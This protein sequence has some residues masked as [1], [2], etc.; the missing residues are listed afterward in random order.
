MATWIDKWM[1]MLIFIGAVSAALALVCTI[2]SIVLR[3]GEQSQQQEIHTSYSYVLM[4]G[5]VPIGA[6]VERTDV[7]DRLVLEQKNNIHPREFEVWAFR[8]KG[9]ADVEL[10]AQYRGDKFRDIFERVVS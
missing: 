5:R 9:T 4:A 8:H 7:L 1:D 3:R 2:V 6:W 10:V